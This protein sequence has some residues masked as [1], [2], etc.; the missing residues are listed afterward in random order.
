MKQCSYLNSSNN[1]NMSI[2]IK[3]KYEYTSSSCA[4]TGTQVGRPKPREQQLKW[5]RGKGR[6]WT[7]APSKRSKTVRWLKNKMLLKFWAPV[8]KKQ[9]YERKGRR[10]WWFVLWCPHL[11]ILGLYLMSYT[12][13][14][15][16]TPTAQ[17]YTIL[18]AM[19]ILALKQTPNN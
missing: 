9:T 15:K 2:I 16:K 3:Y 19:I 4:H 10:S 1:T 18:F 17:S 5:S 14:H 6:S 11:H 13:A 8:L 12:L 7:F